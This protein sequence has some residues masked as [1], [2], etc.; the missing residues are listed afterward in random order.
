VAHV[1]S[2]RGAYRVLMVRLEGKS[3]LERYW[4]IWEDNKKMDLQEVG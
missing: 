2:R 3:P 4:H 1:G